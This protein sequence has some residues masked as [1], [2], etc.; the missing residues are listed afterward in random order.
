MKQR[1]VKWK[2]VRL[3]CG[4]CSTC[5][6]SP[7]YRQ[8]ESNM[9]KPCGHAWADFWGNNMKPRALL[10]ELGWIQQ[11]WCRTPPYWATC[12][13]LSLFAL[14]RHSSPPWWHRRD[15]CSCHSGSA[16]HLGATHLLWQFK[17]K[18]LSWPCSTGGGHKADQG[19]PVGH[20]FWSLPVQ[21]SSD[22]GRLSSNLSASFCICV[23]SLLYV[24]WGGFF[25][26]YHTIY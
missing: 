6:S 7:I 5:T 1:D 13:V 22:T 3:W 12:L 19:S 21:Q 18:G 15:A 11:C 26:I 17:L 2:H 20:Y 23:I 10:I 4:C 8:G 9:L 14:C 25:V 24:F 16:W